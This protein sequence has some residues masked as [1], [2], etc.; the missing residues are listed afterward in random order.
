MDRER[1]YKYLTIFGPDRNN[2]NNYPEK[3]KSILSSESKFHAIYS[4]IKL[5]DI[6]NKKTDFH[7][8]VSQASDN[9]L[10]QLED[11]ATSL[12]ININ[13]ETQITVN[14]LSDSELSSLKGLEM[15]IKISKDIKTLREA[16]IFF[17][18]AFDDF[19]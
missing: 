15:I 3:I 6:S 17:F 5:K 2:L 8:I 13:K 19:N 1:P 10:Y 4:N 11:M 12:G 16:F 18:E 14:G 9:F 7:E